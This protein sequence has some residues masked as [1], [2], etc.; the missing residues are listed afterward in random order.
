MVVKC[1]QQSKEVAQWSNEN[2]SDAITGTITA[3]L[4]IIIVPLLLL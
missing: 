2:Y 4:S 1:S 3:L